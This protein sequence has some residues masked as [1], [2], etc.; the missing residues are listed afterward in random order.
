MQYE[1]PVPAVALITLSVIVTVL[2][3]DIER[4]EKFGVTPG[5]LIIVGAALLFAVLI[6]HNAMR[7]EVKAAGLLYMG[8]LYVITYLVIL[9]T[10][11]NAVLI[12]TRPDLKLFREHD[13]LYV[14]LK[15]WPV[16]TSTLL[17]AT[18][19]TFHD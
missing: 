3:K 2:S 9:G 10:A 8:Y 15:Y 14:K 4:R 19:L 6:S 11:L 7:D 16:I 17:L 18:L 5:S 12:V 1:P 13:N